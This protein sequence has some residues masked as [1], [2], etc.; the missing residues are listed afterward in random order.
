MYANFLRMIGSDKAKEGVDGSDEVCEKVSLKMPYADPDR[1]REFNRNLF[2]VRYHTD[3]EFREAES[4]RKHVWYEKHRE[5]VIAH[6]RESRKKSDRRGTRF[7]CEIG[8][9][10]LML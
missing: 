9:P 6:V 2:Y 7:E 3:P 4:Y 8:S 10:A 5:R 1:Q